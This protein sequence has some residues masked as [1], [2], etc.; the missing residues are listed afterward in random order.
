[1]PELLANVAP[2]TKT[3]VIAT[4]VVVAVILVLTQ[5]LPIAVLAERTSQVVSFVFVLVNLSLIRLKFKNEPSSNHFQVPLVV[6]VLGVATS[7]ML[8]AAGFL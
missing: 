4:C 8:F 6:P 1:M 7:A 5:S 3:P 2:K